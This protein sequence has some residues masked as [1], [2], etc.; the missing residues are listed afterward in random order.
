VAIDEADSQLIF[1]VTDN[2][3]GIDP[4][5]LSESSRGTL[6]M[7]LIAA[8]IGAKVSW[9][10]GPDGKGTTVEIRLHVQDSSS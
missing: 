7:R 9:K 6:Y 4:A 1:S 2:G 5:K 8:L 3:K 10:Q